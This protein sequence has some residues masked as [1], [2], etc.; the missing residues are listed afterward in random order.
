MH[1]SRTLSSASEADMRPFKA[2]VRDSVPG[3]LHQAHQRNLLWVGCLTPQTSSSILRTRLVD[4][5]AAARPAGL[6]ARKA[7]KGP[8]KLGVW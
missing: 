7:R 3:L 1:A 2:R 8:S 5:T 6:I 4:L